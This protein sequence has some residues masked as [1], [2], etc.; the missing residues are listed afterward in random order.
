MSHE[1]FTL[2]VRS[3]EARSSAAGRPIIT[4]EGTEFWV[5]RDVEG[6][7]EATS[8]P[9][10]RS[11][12]TGEVPVDILLF[13]SREKAEEFARRWKG[14]PW[15]CIPDGTFRIIPVRPEYKPVLMG[16]TAV[17]TVDASE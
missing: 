8:R 7:V 4:K 2:V 17:E 6:W 9:C 13:S 15:W 12:R 5:L 14:D 3:K 16:Y 10:C 1:N 11:L